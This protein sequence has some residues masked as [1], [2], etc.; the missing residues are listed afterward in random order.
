[1]LS[2]PESGR[3]GL[4][5]RTLKQIGGTWLSSPWRRVVQS[6]FFLGFVTLFIWVCWPYGGTNYAQ[7]REAKEKIAAELFLILDPL[8]SIST[9]I[10]SKSWVWSLSAAGIILAVCLVVSRAGSADTFARSG[11]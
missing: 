10:A 3:K 5:R 6:L 2:D 1:M 4:I 11:R 8:V 9:A 7:H